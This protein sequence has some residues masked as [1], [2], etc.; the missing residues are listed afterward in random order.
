VLKDKKDKTVI[1]KLTAGF[2]IALI[3]STALTSARGLYQ[4][5]VKKADD[6]YYAYI[7]ETAE[8][9]PKNNLLYL[10]PDDTEMVLNCKDFLKENK[11][12]VFHKPAYEIPP[13]LYDDHAGIVNNSILQIDKEM[14][15]LTADTMKVI[16][17]IV[18]SDY[19]DKITNLYLD[20]DGAIYPLYN[21]R[22][23]LN[24]FIHRLKQYDRSRFQNPDTNISKIDLSSLT[25][26]THPVKIK[27]LTVEG[28]YYIVNQGIKFELE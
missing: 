7:L 4:G 10:C 24:P 28:S 3:L 22:H 6:T 9:Q 1:K 27:A 11:Y 20:I 17:P 14:F 16:A 23:K 19:K 18:T 13:V 21:N 15:Q 8:I 25:S 26:G 5:I 2:I 12:N